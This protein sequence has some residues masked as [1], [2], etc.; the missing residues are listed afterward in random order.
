MCIL[1]D[2]SFDEPY[3][4]S[5]IKIYC[6]C[7]G[8]VEIQNPTISI[9]CSLLLNRHPLTDTYWEGVDYK[10]M[11]TVA[12]RS[13]AAIFVTKSLPIDSTVITIGGAPVKFAVIFPLSK[14]RHIHR[15]GC[16]DSP[17]SS[18]YGKQR[19]TEEN[20]HISPGKVRVLIDDTVCNLCDAI[21]P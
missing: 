1:W 20:P 11:I 8:W 6:I 10:V 13:V 12:L 4:L 18:S 17:Y 5:A 7:I 9:S 2:K 15:T 19:P 16:F 3:L 14:C 21:A